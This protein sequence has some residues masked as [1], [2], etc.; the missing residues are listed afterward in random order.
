VRMSY[1]VIIFYK[2]ITIDNPEV[3][4]ERERAVCEVLDIKGRMIIAN[5]GING[6][7]EGSD[8]NILKYI[9]HI[10]KDKR[11]K[12]M[13]IKESIGSGN[14][15]PKLSIKVKKEIVSTKLDS[16]IDPRKKTS[17]HLN[18]AELKKWYDKKEDF[19]VIDMRNDYE[20]ASGYFKNTINIDLKNSRDLKD[21]LS[22]LEKYNIHKDTKILT[23]C[24]YGVRCEKMSAFLLDQGYS[25]VQQLEG[26]IGKYMQKY[27]GQ[28]FLG[29][30]YTFDQRVTMHFG[31]D[32]VIVGKCIDCGISSET[33]YDIY[34]QEG[35]RLKD[36][37][38]ILCAA[39]AQKRGAT[40]HASRKDYIA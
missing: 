24:T 39:C 35:N 21:K 25:D 9:T 12:L 14:A 13:D 40:M 26:G 22:N 36:T 10:K 32:R 34:N 1:K 2:Y 28:D 31:G 19:V 8:A 18:P 16:H 27:P 5:E 7:L 15:F 38:V 6:T 20:L 17:R 30:L 11:F 33:Y 23:V 37:H 4:M 29:T 3:V